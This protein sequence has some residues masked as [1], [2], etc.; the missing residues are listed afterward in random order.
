MVYCYF[1]LRFNCNTLMIFELGESMAER[2]VHKFSIP[3][4]PPESLCCFSDLCDFRASS[5][6]K[7]LSHYRTCHRNDKYFSSA[8]LY[9]T[10]CFHSRKFGTFSALYTHLRTYHP[11]FDSRQS[12][13]TGIQADG[14]SSVIT[15]N[16]TRINNFLSISLIDNLSNDNDEDA[17]QLNDVLSQEAVGKLNQI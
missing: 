9:S 15:I 11:S 4:E 14:G 10:N 7:L 2:E 12:Y 16:I 5:L 13:S 17:S 6:T 8:C 1:F 3:F